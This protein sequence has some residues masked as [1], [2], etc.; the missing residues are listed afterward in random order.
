MLKLQREMKNRGHAFEVIFLYAPDR[1]ISGAPDRSVV[2][3]V[4]EPSLVD[5]LRMLPRLYKLI[6]NRRP[7]ALIAFLPLACV[8]GSL[9][10]WLAGV[11]RRIAS[12]R[13]TN[14]GFSPIMRGLD[15]I[16]GTLGLYSAIIGNSKAVCDSFRA[17][18]K[19]YTRRLRVVYNGLDFEPS[20]YAPAEARRR[21]GLP[22]GV[23]LIGSTGRLTNQKNYDLLIRALPELPGAHLAI[24]GEGP[25]REDLAGLASELA[26]RERVIFLGAIPRGDIP[27]FLCALDIFALPSRFEGL[28]NSL[29]EALGAGL[30]VVV[31]DIP[32]QLEALRLSKE[33]GFAGLVVPTEETEAWIDE[34]RRLTED[35][36]LRTELATRAR[37]RAKYFSSADMSA[38]YLEAIC[39]AMAR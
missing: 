31:S 20:G 33:G 13:T 38:G 27:A 4:R 15:L 21:L 10:G 30:P 32:E 25:L 24:A 11:E 36:A 28:S 17:Y 19:L 18:P 5:Y 22:L 12:H 23:T 26:V 29:L 35:T 9:A 2:L 34:L 1:D 8:L 14:A 39:E 37:V 3:S 16:A 7:D 6:R